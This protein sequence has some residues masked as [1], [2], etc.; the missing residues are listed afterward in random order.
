M[1]KIALLGPVYQAGTLSGNPLAVT[2]GIETL[3]IL[4]QP[5]TYERLN[6]L[7]EQLSEGLKDAAKSA[8]IST[9]PTRVGS[10]LCTF[11]TES[12]VTDYESA[13]KS[14]TSA[15]ARFFLAMLEEGVYLAP[16]QFEAVFLSTVHTEEHIEKTIRAARKAFKLSR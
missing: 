7:S 13:K 12:P 11:F 4:K 16:S 14:D 5:G 8:G 1:E 6:R 2:A 3:K 10:M 9:Y 15:F